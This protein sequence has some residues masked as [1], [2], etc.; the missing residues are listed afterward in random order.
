MSTVAEPLASST[1]EEKHFEGGRLVLAKPEREHSVDS[2]SSVEEASAA[3]TSPPADPI[4]DLPIHRV[5]RLLRSPVPGHAANIS[6]RASAARRVQKTHGNRASQ[7]II[8]RSPI[9]QRQCACGGTCAKC[10]EE[11]QRALQRSSAAPAPAE[12]DGIPATHGTPLDPVARQPLEAHFG[13]D[14]ADVRVHTEPE[15]AE[16]A[17]KLDALAYTSGRDIYFAAGMYAP[18]SSGG[19]RLLAHEVAHVMQQSSGLEPTIATKSSGGAKIGAPDDP[20]EDEAERKAEEF[21]S[22][23]QPGELSDEEQPRRR[24]AGVVQ[25][26]IQRQPA[27]DPSAPPTPGAAPPD[28]AAAPPPSTPSPQTSAAK[29][30]PPIPFAGLMV[31]DDPV[32][33][34]QLMKGLVAHGMPDAFIPPGIG[35]PDIYANKMILGTGF[36]APCG[37]PNSP[38]Y[39]Y[40]HRYELLHSRVLPALLSVTESLRTQNQALID[41]FGNK[42][43]AITKDTLAANKAQTDKEAARYGINVSFIEHRE[44]PEGGVPEPGQNEGESWSEKVTTMQ[45]ASPSSQGLSN[46]AKVLLERRSVIDQKKAEQQKQYTYI[47]HGMKIPNARYYELGKEITDLEAQY[48]VL[49]GFLDA[50]YPIL[51]DFSDLEK[52]PDALRQI[53]QGPGADSAAILA[54][55]IAEVR[56]NIEESEAGL[57]DG[58]VNP[59]KL[60]RML[61]I[62]RAAEGIDADPVKKSLIDQKVHDEQDGLLDAIALGVLNIAALLLAGP[63]GGLSLA[64]AAGVNAALLYQHAQ[65]YLMQSAISGSA[66]DRANAI[67]QDEPSLFWLAFELVGTVMDVGTAGAKV[68]ESFAK[69]A[70]AF[71]K[72]RPAVKFAQG[73]EEGAEL[74]KS[75]NGVRAAARD[76]G[77]ADQAES[78]VAHIR[79]A[80]KG[81][82]PG[83]EV[84]KEAGVVTEEEAGTLHAAAQA[85]EEEAK[86]GAA[87]ARAAT[88]PVKISRAGHIFTCHSP[89]QY[90]LDKYLDLLGTEVTLEGES[91]SLRQ[92]YLEFEKRAEE[93]AA[94]VRAAPPEQLAQAEE[95]AASVENEI[96]AFEKKLADARLS[97]QQRKIAN[98][99]QQVALARQYENELPGIIDKLKAQA[100]AG[101]RTIN[102]DA[103]SP[104]EREVLEQIFHDRDVESLTLA[105]LQL[106]RGR[107]GAEASQLAAKLAEAEDALAESFNL[108]RPYLRDSTKDTIEKAATNKIRNPD[109]SFSYID[110]DGKVRK[111]PWEYGHIYGRENRRL[112]VEAGEKGLTQEQFNDWVNSHPDWFRME[113]REFNQSHLGEKPGID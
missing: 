62:A 80:R 14:L 35:A 49:R 15:A 28:A 90:L 87:G 44:S 76:A 92:Q 99:S 113:S 72:L 12:F 50:Q 54:A 109:G 88:S 93:A 105:D 9:L 71:A 111:P 56:Q 19:R 91:T 17:A 3:V 77:V 83:L 101:Q 42:T 85:A 82:A 106:G 110:P 32:R 26:Y 37:D 47:E 75:L 81:G 64:V 40:C 24:D 66:L 22:G 43:K 55:R 23:S 61:D 39:E 29:I 48:T 33:L 53:S 103:L 52:D 60:P 36:R 58:R 69:A 30:D 108:R 27:P 45:T 7:Q 67:S 98:L 86:V 63:T 5:I 74:E 89:C 95:A 112:I 59:W 51:A 94:R 34:E 107:S 25:R 6:T 46:A 16:S 8:M 84:L 57:D 10:Q 78:I 96:A 21:M 70:G 20:L 13:A 2:E 104:H 1:H 4:E 11:E 41:D 31:D 68:A 79:S 73:A 102:L 100:V 65:D 18:S 38:D 97:P